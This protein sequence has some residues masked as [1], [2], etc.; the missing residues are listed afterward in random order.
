MG[1]NL[2]YVD[3]GTN[4]T[5]GSTAMPDGNNAN[6]AV[7]VSDDL[8]L[9]AWGNNDYGQLGTGDDEVGENIG[10]ES[11]EMGDNLPVI[12][13][14]RQPTAL[15]TTEPTFNPTM[16][17]T[18][19]ESQPL[20]SANQRQTCM[21]YQ[22]EVK[23]WGE[24]VVSDPAYCG[25]DVNYTTQPQIDGYDLGDVDGD[26]NVSDVRCGLSHS[27]ALGIDGSARCW[28]NNTYVGR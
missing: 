11:D 25:G 26:F 5:F 10:D 15:P 2:D 9:K 21:A 20:F 24:N 8:D 27:C 6:H 14:D 28:G 4:A 3:L 13:F 23:C 16:A 17:P 7:L 22:N 12:D 18:N 1:D 19:L